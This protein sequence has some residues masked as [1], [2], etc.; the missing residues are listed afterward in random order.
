MNFT[1]FVIKNHPDPDSLLYPYVTMT[2][3]IFE[4]LSG[5]AQ[6]FA[7]EQSIEFVNWIR[8]NNFLYSPQSHVWTDGTLVLSNDSL[9]T[10]YHESQ[11]I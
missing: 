6:Q 1:E 11:K 2:P 3:N 5:L 8:E 10:R 7:D 4:Q 9:L